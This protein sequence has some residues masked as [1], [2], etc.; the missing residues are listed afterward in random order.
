MKT[1]SSYKLSIFVYL[2]SFQRVFWYLHEDPLNL[3][4]K[5]LLLSLKDLIISRNFKAHDNKV[6]LV[7]NILHLQLLVS[8]KS[9]IVNQ[10]TISPE[11]LGYAFSPVESHCHAAYHLLIQVLLR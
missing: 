11:L 3:L 9:L 7:L 10:E 1:L 5:E 4:I 2:V 6:Y 8:T